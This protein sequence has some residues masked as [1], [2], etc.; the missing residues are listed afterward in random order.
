[1]YEIGVPNSSREAATWEGPAQQGR[2]HP[3]EQPSSGWARRRV[4]RQGQ[5]SKE[6]VPALPQKSI[7]V[8]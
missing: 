7:P 5:V 2:V 3:K 4:L 8:I 6:S 1:M